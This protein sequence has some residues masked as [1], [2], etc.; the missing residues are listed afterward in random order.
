MLY[1][2]KET[3]KEQLGQL[4]K[5]LKLSEVDIATYL[6]KVPYRLNKEYTAFEVRRLQSELYE[7]FGIVAG[8]E[9]VGEFLCKDKLKTEKKDDG[10]MQII[11]LIGSLVD[12]PVDSFVKTKDLAA[13]Q[14]SKLKEIAQKVS[15]IKELEVFDVAVE[16]FKSCTKK[17]YEMFRKF[18]KEIK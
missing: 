3:S 4:S 17:E 1:Q 6:M 8:F 16:E 18:Y 10:A 12:S 15:D 13:E 9:N 2:I 7:N 14:A 11:G 5:I